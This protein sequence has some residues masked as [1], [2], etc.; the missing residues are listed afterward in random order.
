MDQNSRRNILLIGL[1]LGM[2]F[3]ALDQTVV[4]TAMPR[5]IGELGGLDILAWVTTAYMLSSTTFVPIAGKLADIYGRRIMYVTGLGLFMLGSAL[6]GTSEN[7]TQLIIYRGLQGIGGGILMPMA[8]T[9]VGD[10]FPPDKRGKWQGV[11]G[12]LFGLS[13]IVGPSLGGWIVD[14]TSWRWVFYINLP[15]GILAAIT[16]F[17]GLSGEK[18]LKAEAPIDFA[19]A[20]TLIIAVASL[21]LGLS[22]GGKEYPWNSWQIISLFAI[23]LVFLLIFFRVEKSAREPILSLNLFKNRIFTVANLVGFLMGFGMFGAIM[24][25]PLFMQGVLGISATNSGNTMIPMMFAMVFTSI[26]GGQLVSKVGFRNLLITGMALMTL[27]FY[28]LSTMT[29]DTTRLVV[30]LYIIVLGLGMGLVMPTLTIAVQYAFP[31]EQ[32]GVATSATQ[33]FRSI[34]GTFG[35]TIFGVVL[36]HRSIELLKKDFLPVVQKIPG[37]ATGPFANFLEKAKTDPQ[38][39][40]NTLLRPEVLE[41]IPP[42]LKEI[43]VPPLKHALAESI[44]YVFWVAM[45]II[46]FGIFL[47]FFMENIKVEKQPGGIISKEKPVESGA[48]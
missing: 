2:F 38:G 9:I 7:M 35:V 47:S 19:G 41:K 29:V 23:S 46:V 36:N 13:S 12:A 6:C 14:H 48:K 8:M 11:M 3:S 25:L 21:L 24:F 42:Q 40:F 26:L 39:L 15:V 1:I 44:H 27:G 20:L 32:R 10:V 31:L 28:L 18:R 22:L 37:L 34:G 17:I 43:I 33:F 16:V 30:T 5:I 4:G 45:F